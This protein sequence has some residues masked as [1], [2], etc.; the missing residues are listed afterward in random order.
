MAKKCRCLIHHPT[1]AKERKRVVENLHYFRRLGDT[2]G[3]I[4]SMAALTGKCPA[5]AR[6][7]KK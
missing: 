3:I 5:V 4:I 6:V 7:C 1:S 2:T